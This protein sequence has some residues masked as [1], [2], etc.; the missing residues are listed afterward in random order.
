MKVR[1][2][3]TFRFIYMDQ[4]RIVIICNIHANVKVPCELRIYARATLILWTSSSCEITV[5]VVIFS[6]SNGCYYWIVNTM[7]LHTI[8]WGILESS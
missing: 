5:E 1:T 4:D 2:Y 8:Y 7:L 6:P 3:L